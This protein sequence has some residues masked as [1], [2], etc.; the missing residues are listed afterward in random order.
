[1]FC[2]FLKTVVRTQ[3]DPIYSRRQ[4]L[5]DETSPS[6]NQSS[7]PAHNEICC[8]KLFI[9]LHWPPSLCIS[10]V[11][12]QHAARLSC[13]DVGNMEMWAVPLSLIPLQHVVTKANSQG[14]AHAGWQRQFQFTTCVFN[15]RSATNSPG[16]FNS[17]TATCDFHKTLWTI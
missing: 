9:W 5:I 6:A 15:T 13:R 16:G 1:M 7:W 8:L 3:K 14:A 4:Q 10:S 2:Y 12:E 17:L 11:M